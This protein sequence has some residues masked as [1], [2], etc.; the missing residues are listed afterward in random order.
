MYLALVTKL[1]I[2]SCSCCI[3]HCVLHY[4]IAVLLHL[5]LLLL[6]L[7]MCRLAVSIAVYPVRFWFHGWWRVRVFY[8]NDV[9]MTW[10][11]HVGWRMVHRV[12]GL[13]FSMTYV[14]VSVCVGDVDVLVATTV[15]Y[16]KCCWSRGIALWPE[17]WGTSDRDDRC[18]QI[19]RM[20]LLV[21][22]RTAVPGANPSL[23]VR[24]CMES[25]LS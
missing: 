13:L 14:A 9:L 15:P 18:L 7:L 2:L 24:D 8:V 3:V 17:A 5:I 25:V 11:V 4:G 12:T 20:W 22:Q 1:S 16:V 10:H 6:L 23:I 19:H 21:L